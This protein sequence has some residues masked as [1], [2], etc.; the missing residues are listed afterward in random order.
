MSKMIDGEKIQTIIPADGSIT[1]TFMNTKDGKI[2]V[3]FK[4]HNVLVTPESSFDSE[5]KP[6]TELLEKMRKSLDKAIAFT[7]TPQELTEKFE[8]FITKRQTAERDLVSAINESTED[9]NRRIKELKEKKSA[10]TV[11]A[12]TPD[13]AAQTSAKPPIKE[14]KAPESK[15]ASGTETGA[16]TLFCEDN[17][18]EKEAA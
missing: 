2:A 13:K 14:T 9:L 5:I 11:T 1:I 18:G 16:G 4:S 6:K 3:L 7:A 12:K 15:T 8:E 10:K 17:K